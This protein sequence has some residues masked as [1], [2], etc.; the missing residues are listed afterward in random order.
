MSTRSCQFGTKMFVLLLM[1][2]IFI[3]FLLNLLCF[4]LVELG[5]NSLDDAI[6]SNKSLNNFDLRDV[7]DFNGFH[8]IHTF[9]NFDEGFNS[10]D[11]NI[12]NSLK[13]IA[14]YNKYKS[15]FEYGCIWRFNSLNKVAVLM[16]YITSKKS[17]KFDRSSD[18]LSDA[19]YQYF[20]LENALNYCYIYKY[21]LI[22]G[23]KSIFKY[24]KT[25]SKKMVKYM[26]SPH[27]QK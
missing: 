23:T 17:L 25:E 12:N 19:R 7:N 10:I 16:I 9:L 14:K 6:L 1:I 21:N 3:L 5:Q 11:V 13:N 4:K 20:K 26:N 15:F 27:F 24:K 2:L 18:P 22:F 8:P